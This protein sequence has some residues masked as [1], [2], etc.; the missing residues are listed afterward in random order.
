MGILFSQ[1]I[2]GIFHSFEEKKWEEGPDFCIDINR[3]KVWIEAVAC[4]HGEEDPVEPWPNLR[5]GQIYSDGGNIEEINRPRAL[6]ITSVV[7]TKL[8]QYKKYLKNGVVSKDDCLVIAVNGQAIQHKSEASM[9]FKYAIFGQGPDML[10]RRAGKNTFQSGFYK[11]IETLIKYARGEEIEVPPHFM[12]MDEFADIGAVI[13]S[14]YS[15][16]SSLWN[17]KQIGGDLLFAY[18]NNPSNPIPQDLFK[19][20]RAVRKDPKTSAISELPQDQ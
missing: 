7:G 14:G 3:K 10:V 6:R 15:T 20:G 13:Y 18:H 2:F 11:P 9:L 1:C 8:E 16:G 5:P 19:F 4:T 12:E 17:S